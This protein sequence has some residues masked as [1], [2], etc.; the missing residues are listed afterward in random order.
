MITGISNLNNVDTSTYATKNDV[1]K[2][3][4]VNDDAS[5][6]SANE[7]EKDTFVK[8][9]DDDLTNL[10]YKPVK[11]KLSAEEIKQLNDDQAEQEKAF[12]K[13]FIENTINTQ[14]NF[15]NGTENNGLSKE[16]SDLLTKIFGSLDKAYPKAGTTPEE[17]QKAIS[18]GG[19]YSV[20][21]VADRIM[22]M[23]TA[24]AGD[25][26]DKLQ[27]MR[28]AVEEGFKQAGVDFKNSTKMD[29]LPQISK[30]TYTEV[31]KR[32]DALQ[33]K[34]DTSKDASANK[35]EDNTIKNN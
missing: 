25:D 8:S 15:S 7:L 18:D 5:N 35:Q 33:G 27:Q 1:S 2:K 14:N 13:K 32:F 30:D 26:K 17:A 16:S 4:K 29:D 19:P 23:A 31:M 34:S 24:L 21:A 10:T 9:S 11:K 22:T 6:T 20:K 28:N 12:L 3:D